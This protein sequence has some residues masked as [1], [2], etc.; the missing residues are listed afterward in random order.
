MPNAESGS[1]CRSA[2]VRR[3]CGLVCV[4]MAVA[5]LVLLRGYANSR[6]ATAFSHSGCFVAQ[7]AS[8]G[9]GALRD[10]CGDDA[11]ARGAVTELAEIN[12]LPGAEV[13]PAAGHG[14]GEFDARE[15]RFGMCGHVVVAFERV[16][17]VGFALADQPVEDGRE[18]RADVGIGV[19]VDRKTCGGVFDE[20]MH[21]PGVGQRRQVGRDF[22]RDEVKAA[23][24]GA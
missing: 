13:E 24:A 18:V 14:N 10:D 1:S 21:Q 6:P 23:G 22:V 20:E 7:C 2:A 11:A 8:P 17:V 5:A 12:P 4:V 19:F 9:D 16:D 15:C 3:S